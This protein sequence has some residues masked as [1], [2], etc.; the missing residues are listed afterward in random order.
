MIRYIELGVKKMVCTK[1]TI[2]TIQK[3]IKNKSNTGMCPY[4][5]NAPLV[6]SFMFSEPRNWH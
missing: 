2:A 3:Y 1:L 4:Y 6:L 5:T